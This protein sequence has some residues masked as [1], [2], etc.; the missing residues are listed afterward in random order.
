MELA[1]DQAVENFL[2]STFCCVQPVY[3]EFGGTAERFRSP[4]LGLHDPDIPAVTMTST[5]TRVRNRRQTSSN[6]NDNASI[7]QVLLKLKYQ[8]GHYGTDAD[9]ACE[10]KGNILCRG[11]RSQFCGGVNIDGPV[12]SKPGTQLK[13]SHSASPHLDG[14]EGTGGETERKGEARKSDQVVDS[15]GG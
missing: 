8:P 1:I 9:A 13:P 7:S 6:Q 3:C 15:G 2:Y 5:G 4:N 11:C 10:S 14:R 12:G